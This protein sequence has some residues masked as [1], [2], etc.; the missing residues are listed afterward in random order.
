MNGEDVEEDEEEEDEEEEE[1]EE[2]E[3]GEEQGRHV[4]HGDD[5]E[6]YVFREDEEKRA[7]GREFYRMEG[8]AARMAGGAQE[9]STSRTGTKYRLGSQSLFD[10]EETPSRIHASSSPPLPGL[11]LLTLCTC[12]SANLPMVA[13]GV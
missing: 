3:E 11:L 5:V 4:A 10:S 13:C 6:M 12:V 2:E 1:E 9:A 7:Q 8:V